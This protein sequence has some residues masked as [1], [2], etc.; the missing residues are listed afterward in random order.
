VEG[1]CIEIDGHQVPIVPENAARIRAPIRAFVRARRSQR[2]AGP[3][4]D[5]PQI[6]ELEHRLYALLEDVKQHLRPNMP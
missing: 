2:P 1:D 5:S 4:A 6:R 3:K